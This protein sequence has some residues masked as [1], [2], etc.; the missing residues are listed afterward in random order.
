MR[1]VTVNK[2]IFIRYADHRD[3]GLK[4]IR[5]GKEENQIRSGLLHELAEKVIQIESVKIC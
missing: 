5:V 3:L 4:I 1:V 2:L